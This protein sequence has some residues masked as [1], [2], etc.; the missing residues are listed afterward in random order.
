M[1]RSES[2]Q[3]RK[4]LARLRQ[5]VAFAQDVEPNN[6]VCNLIARVITLIELSRE[7]SDLELDELRLEFKSVLKGVEKY[8]PEIVKEAVETDLDKRFSE[9]LCK[10]SDNPLATRLLG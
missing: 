7:L 4:E 8:L 1:Q 9:A 10:K 3:F 6:D 2:N 5:D